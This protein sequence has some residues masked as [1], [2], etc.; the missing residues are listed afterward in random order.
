MSGQE[1]ACSLLDPW[2]VPVING[3]HSQWRAGRFRLTKE[4]VEAELEHGLLTEDELLC[5]LTPPARLL[6]RAPISDFQV[7]C[8]ADAL[9]QGAGSVPWVPDD[10][11]LGYAAGRW[12]G[13]RAG[14]CLWG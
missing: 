8:A 7:G 5:A 12:R 4:E 14:A 2:H 9:W 3:I 11:V 13:A 6:A 10:T 1:R